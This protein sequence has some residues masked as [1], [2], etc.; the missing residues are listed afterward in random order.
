MDRTL[1]TFQMLAQGSLK[2]DEAETV[3]LQL[4][5]GEAAYVIAMRVEEVARGFVSPE[6]AARFI[7]ECVT[8]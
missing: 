8:D 2:P 1:K 5:Q 3:L 7:L 6:D 4:L